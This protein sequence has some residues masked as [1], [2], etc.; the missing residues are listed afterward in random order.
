MR[1]VSDDPD[2]AINMTQGN[3]RTWT[4]PITQV[5]VTT[6]KQT[7]GVWLAPSSDDKTEY[8]Y[9]LNEATKATT[10]MTLTCP[11]ELR[12]YPTR[13]YNYDPPKVQLSIRS[14]MFL[15]ERMQ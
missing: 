14:Y 8:Q 1:T 11:A 3:D 5:E 6:S 9:Q 4:M 2:I 7:L 12:K 15:W 13:F 10:T